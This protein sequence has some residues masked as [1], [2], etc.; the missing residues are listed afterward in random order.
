MAKRLT[1]VPRYT[2]Y[3]SA[4]AAK[5]AWEAGKDFTSCDMD[6]YGVAVNKADAKAAGF[7]D[8]NIRYKRNA[9]I[10]TAKI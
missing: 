6:Y 3:T 5:A 1:V 2:D 9:E 7:T 8:V 10:C 4:K